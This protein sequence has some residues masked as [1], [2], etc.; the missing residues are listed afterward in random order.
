VFTGI[1]RQIGTVRTATGTPAG[2]RLGIDLGA[3]AEGLR[4]GDSVAVSGAC[5]TAAEVNGPVA[6]FDVVAETLQR[7]TLGRLAPGGEVNLERALALGDRL[8]GHLVQGHVDGVARVTTVGPDGGEWR[9]ECASRELAGK[10]VAKGSVA[11][12]G[13][14]LTLTDATAERFAV[15]LVPET[16]SATTLAGLAV[17]DPVNVE[18]DL[19]GKYVRKYLAGLGAA[20]G[21]TLDKLRGAGFA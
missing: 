2:R 16:L 14:S 5:L 19:I 11:L 3:L 12:D 13:V 17:G 4:R 8:D 10:M 7:T 9:I 1:I 20:D 6:A 21:L 18:L 15:A